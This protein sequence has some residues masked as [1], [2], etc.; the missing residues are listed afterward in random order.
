[1]WMRVVIA[2]YT[3]SRLAR[4]LYMLLGVREAEGQR[5]GGIEG[6]RD[7]QSSS[8]NKRANLCLD[9]ASDTQTICNE[10]AETV[11]ADQSQTHKKH[12]LPYWHIK[13]CF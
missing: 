2:Q 12:V 4:R 9:T 6:Q 10:R 3:Q 7:G 8:Q 13:I 1:M 11:L 5:S